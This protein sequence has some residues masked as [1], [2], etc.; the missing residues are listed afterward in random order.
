ME[1]AGGIPVLAR[2]G[3]RMN[4]ETVFADARDAVAGGQRDRLRPNIIQHPPKQMTQ[5]LM[6]VVHQGAGVEEALEI[7]RNGRH[8]S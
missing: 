4:E 1:A 6:A 2:G 5:A 3:S 8:A 7:L